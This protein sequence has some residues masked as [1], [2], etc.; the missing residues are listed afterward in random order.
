MPHPFPH[1]KIDLNE[2]SV[3]MPGDNV[4]GITV[5]LPGIVWNAAG[6]TYA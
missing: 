4:P 3:M 2:I 6:A 5:N 1:T